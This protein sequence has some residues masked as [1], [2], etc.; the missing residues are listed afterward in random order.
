MENRIEEH[1]EVNKK[2]HGLFNV[3]HLEITQCKISFK[4]HTKKLPILNE[5]HLNVK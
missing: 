5:N 3:M 1:N 2:Q 4:K